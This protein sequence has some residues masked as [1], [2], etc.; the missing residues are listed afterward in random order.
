M[1]NQKMVTKPSVIPICSLTAEVRPV[2]DTEYNVKELEVLM[3]SNK[4]PTT[5]VYLVRGSE[6]SKN[7]DDPQKKAQTKFCFFTPLGHTVAKTTYTT[8]HKRIFYSF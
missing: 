3:M 5:G 7:S 4:I 2:M 6:Q 8:S 1:S